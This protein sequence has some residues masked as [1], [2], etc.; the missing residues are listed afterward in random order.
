[1]FAKGRRPTPDIDRHVKNSASNAAHQLALSVRGPLEMQT[2]Q[3]ASRRIKSMIVL[4]E[5]RLAKVFQPI[6]PKDFGKKSPVV[7]INI[8]GNQSD[9]RDI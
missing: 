4:N 2:S 5:N 9:V 6:L 8:R 3:N 1:M 7:P